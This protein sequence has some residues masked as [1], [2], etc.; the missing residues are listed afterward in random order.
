MRDEAVQLAL[1]EKLTPS[2]KLR[3][4]PSVLAALPYPLRGEGW[5]RSQRLLQ[6]HDIQPAVELIPHRLVAPDMAEA[7][8]LVQAHRIGPLGRDHRD[9]LLEPGSPALRHQ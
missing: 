1:T 5:P 9:H 6:V 7:G 4:G 2:P 8:F 3:Y